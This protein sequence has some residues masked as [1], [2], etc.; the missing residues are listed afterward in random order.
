MREVLMPPATDVILLD[1]MGPVLLRE[2]VALN[3]AHSAAWQRGLPARRAAPASRPPPT[4]KIDT[5]RAI[6]ESSIDYIS[7]S[8]I[9][10]A[11]PTLD[12]LASIALW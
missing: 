2:A 10:M 4:T 6:A 12:M 9:T 3:P 11:A 5:V 1:N 7:T 8:K